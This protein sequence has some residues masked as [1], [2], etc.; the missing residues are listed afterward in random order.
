MREAGDTAKKG[1]L[2]RSWEQLGD[3]LSER[4]EKPAGLTTFWQ[5][6]R[7]PESAERGTIAA[8]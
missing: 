6:P 3:P 1:E 2:V 8:R 5:K 4:R 7:D